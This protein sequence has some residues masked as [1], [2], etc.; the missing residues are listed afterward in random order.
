MSPCSAPVFMA[1][2]GF[3]GVVWLVAQG[4]EIMFDS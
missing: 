1:G 2:A 4:G 3:A